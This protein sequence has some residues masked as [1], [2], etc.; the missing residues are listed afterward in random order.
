[1]IKQFLGESIFVSVVALLLSLLITT[2]VLPLFNQL[3]ERSLSLS[4]SNNF[5]LILLLVLLVLFVGTAA[6]I[7]PAFV[8]SSFKPTEVLKGKFIRSFKG[9]M[10]RKVLVSFQFIISIALIASTIIV[11]RQL[12]YMQ[13]KNP[14]FNKEQVLVVTLPKNSEA[15]KLAALK[16][17]LSNNS[18]ITSA[19]AASTLPGVI[20]PVNMVHTENTNPGQNASMQMLFVDEDFVR[21]MQ[22]KIVAG[23]SFSKK[24]AT[25]ENEGFILNEEAVKQSGWQTPEQAIGKKFE[26]VMP[27]RVLKSGKIIG[28]VKDFN[29]APL[30]SAVQPLVMH[31]APNRFQYLFVR[32]NNLTPTTAIN[33]T[34]KKFKEIYA[35]QP[36]EYNF[37]DD[38]VNS[39]YKSEAKMG[40]VFE[41]F[42]VLAI[43]IACLGILGLSVY[44]IHQ[45]TKEI[46]IRKVLGANTA[47]VVAELSK[48]FLK[49]VIIAAIIAAPVAYFAMNKWLQSF[50]YRINID[51]WMFAV[52]GL[53]AL[54]IALITVSFQAIKAAIANPVKSLRT[55]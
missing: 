29:I 7:Y 28:V 18:R 36:F 1:L 19:S 3:S 54:L 25:D 23:R 44:S 31:I 49:P 22:M 38:T 33:I 47:G 32:Y 21:T 4:L 37:L 35:T 51:W 12:Q 15:E 27:D 48:D 14:G 43:L 9:D 26:W 40:N 53:I 20:I 6:G 55:E 42:S 39:L 5:Y 45:R 50:A 41:Y 24:F 13:T 11:Y 8:L 34:Q 10:L 2:L 52:A 16:T 46:G 17:S 30:K